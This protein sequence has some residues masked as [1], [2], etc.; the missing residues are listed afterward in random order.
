MV[1]LGHIILFGIRA[2][3]LLISVRI[4]LSWLPLPYNRFS[5]FL[6]SATD[7]IL[8]FFKKVMPIQIGFLDLSPIV[9]L[10]LLSLADNMVVEILFHGQVFNLSFVLRKIVL[11]IHF[12]FNIAVNLYMFA[13][14]ILLLIALINP[15]IFNPIITMIRSF[16]DPLIS[17]FRRVLHIRSK[18]ADIIYLLII[19]VFLICVLSLNWM[20]TLH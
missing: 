14:V 9:P 20:L 2:F 8:K 11:L 17:W 10:V 13:A 5:E 4:L 15:R 16:I 1:F 19:I 6:N 3:M 7:P 12:I 18:H